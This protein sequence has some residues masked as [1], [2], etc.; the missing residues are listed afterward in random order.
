MLT[1][2][3]Y[4]LGSFKWILIASFKAHKHAR[5]NVSYAT[6]YSTMGHSTIT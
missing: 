4:S 3:R 1:E 5:T 2:Y 6:I